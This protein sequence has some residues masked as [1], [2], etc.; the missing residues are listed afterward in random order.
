MNH[1][2]IWGS[3]L[4]I[5]LC[6]FMFLCIY[7]CLFV[8]DCVSYIFSCVWMHILACIDVYDYLYAYA[9]MVIWVLWIHFLLDVQ[10]W[11]WLHICACVHMYLLTY[12]S[13]MC[14]WICVQLWE[15]VFTYVNVCMCMWAH[16]SRY[17]FVYI[18][19]PMCDMDFICIYVCMHIFGIFT[20]IQSYLCIFS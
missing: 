7:F 18:Y 17:V 8:H 14:T 12:M 11:M 19:L 16:A 1:E 9:Y 20:Y 13:C 5:H 6:V 4:Y 10:G 2:C 3:L 15:S